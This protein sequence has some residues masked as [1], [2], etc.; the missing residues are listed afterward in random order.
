M[1]SSCLP[2]PSGSIRLEP[3]L[4]DTYIK[5]SLIYLMIFTI[6]SGNRH[7]YLFGRQRIISRT[8]KKKAR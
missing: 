2:I 3:E 5:H 8:I 1:A 7:H 6:C 4:Q